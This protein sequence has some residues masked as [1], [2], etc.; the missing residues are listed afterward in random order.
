M[1]S[2]VIVLWRM[3]IVWDK[4]RLVLALAVLLSVT[5][6]ALNVANIVQIRQ[7][8]DGILRHQTSEETRVGIAVVFMSLVSNACATLLVGVKV[9][10]DL[11]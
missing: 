2:D 1:L 10:Y 7:D 3:Y 8:N 9:W 11:C 6:F 5:T 4:S